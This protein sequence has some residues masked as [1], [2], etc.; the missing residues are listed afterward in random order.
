MKKQ[1]ID[2]HPCLSE[3]AHGKYERIHL[4][5]A[6]LCNIKCRYCTRKYDCVNESRPGVTTRVLS[7]IE[8]LE[9]LEVLMRR[10]SRIQVVGVAGPGDALANPSTFEFFR[11]VREF[12][13]ELS[14]CVATNG[15][16]LSDCINVLEELEI[17]AITITINA[18][19]A[20]TALK[21]YSWIYYRKNLIRGMEGVE[22]LIKNQWKGLNLAAKR[23]FT[24]K[25]NSIVIPGINEREIV[26]IADK[27]SSEGANFM[28]ITPVI[29]NG[30]FS[31][32]QK[33]SCELLNDLRER[34]SLF[35]PQ[36][37]HCRQCRADAV[38]GLHE[39]KDMELELLLSQ[40]SYDYCELV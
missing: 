30:E 4:P 26:T 5:V 29:P 16:A 37:K 39:E 20:E 7:P 11:L 23:G 19:R 35:L 14:L 12:Y 18:M 6:P 17:N 9:R 24:I 31:R 2:I 34:C 38:G 22:V 8:A 33:P 10:N 21:I 3:A 25:I 40:L 27:A 28:N 13:P 15:L 1:S 32:I 36:I